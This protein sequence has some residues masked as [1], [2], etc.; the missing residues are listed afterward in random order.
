[1][2]RRI[3]ASRRGIGPELLPELV[4]SKRDSFDDSF[5]KKVS[6]WS[7]LFDETPRST[8]M[9]NS[10][11]Y[12]IQEMAYQRLSCA[13]ATEVQTVL[14]SMREISADQSKGRLLVGYTAV[15]REASLVDA[16]AGRLLAELTGM[17]EAMREI[18]GTLAIIP[19]YDYIAGT[20]KVSPERISS[21]IAGRE[22][23]GLIMFNVFYSGLEEWLGIA[24]LNGRWAAALQHLFTHEI[25]HILTERFAKEDFEELMEIRWNPGADVLRGNTLDS[26]KR[27]AGQIIEAS[28]EL[29]AIERHGDGADAQAVHIAAI[30]L[31]QLRRGIIA[32]GSPEYYAKIAE[33]VRIRLERRGV[34]LWDDEKFLNDVSGLFPRAK[35]VAATVHIDEAELIKQVTDGVDE[36]M[37]AMGKL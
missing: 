13:P 27:R 6:R 15:N 30:L 37:K 7:Q 21:L 33:D 18:N 16:V 29:Y 4:S 2:T 12:E 35:E 24:K 1:M 5:S 32:A 26:K 9:T 3:A 14:K 20:E 11:Y 19:F 23:N 8:Q 10:A 28:A 22:E 36:I 31:T 17:S 25:G 34:A